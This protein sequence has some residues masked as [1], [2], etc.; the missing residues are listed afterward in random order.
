M[1]PLVSVPPAELTPAFKQVK[2]AREQSPSRFNGFL[3]SSAAIRAIR[4]LTDYEGLR[5]DAGL[6]KMSDAS[7][8]RHHH[9]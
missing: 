2:T 4:V 6:M 7:L 3:D 8:H 5:R 9:G 1:L